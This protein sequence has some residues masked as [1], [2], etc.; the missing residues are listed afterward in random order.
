MQ[1]VWFICFL[2]MSHFIALQI[3][4]FSTYHRYFLPTLPLLV[5]Y[6]ALVGWLLYKFQLH[7]FFL[8][9]L[10]IVAIWLFVLARRNSRQAQTM[11]L[12]AGQDADRVR[13]IAES[14][15]KTK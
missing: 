4:R 13:L 3:F 7:A 14:S 11:L 1:I 2:F 8:W 9:Q 12:L 15:A 6:S 10:A 5:G